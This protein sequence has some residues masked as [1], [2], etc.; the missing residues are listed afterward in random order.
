MAHVILTG[1]TG[2]KLVYILEDCGWAQTFVDHV[3]HFKT[4]EVH[5]CK[6]CT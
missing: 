5:D 1:Y 3:P 4:D 6:H 2:S